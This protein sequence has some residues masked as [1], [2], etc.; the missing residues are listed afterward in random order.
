MSGDLAS[1]KTMKL[2]LITMGLIVALFLFAAL[3]EAVFEV[4]VPYVSEVLAALTGNAGLGTARNVIS[5]SPARR[6][7]GQGGPPPQDGSA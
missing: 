1:S 3:M 7:N 4:H 6:L 2:I 5:D